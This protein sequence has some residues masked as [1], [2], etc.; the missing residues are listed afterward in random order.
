MSIL[1]SI[2]APRDHRLGDHSLRQTN[3]NAGSTGGQCRDWRLDQNLIHYSTLSRWNQ[4]GVR[5][6]LEHFGMIKGSFFWEEGDFWNKGDFRNVLELFQN[7]FLRGGRFC[8]IVKLYYFCQFEVC[9]NRY[10]HKRLVR[11]I[12]CVTSGL[13]PQPYWS[14]I[15]AEITWAWGDN[16]NV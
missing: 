5:W 16:S 7:P 9:Y 14:E 10:F 3:R 15:S 1:D 2:I 13:N 8:K 6:F 4:G 12:K 11:L